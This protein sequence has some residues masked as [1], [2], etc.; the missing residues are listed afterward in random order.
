MRI[1]LLKLLLV[2]I[3]I[4]SLTA[5]NVYAIPYTFWKIQKKID[6]R[7]YVPAGTE[8]EGMLPELKG[9]N[10]LWGKLLTARLETDP[11]KAS[12]IYREIISSEGGISSIARLELARIRYASDDY[13][14]V[15]RLLSILPD[16]EESKI[17]LESLFFRGLSYKML[18]D[19]YRAR[20]DFKMID[21]GNYLYP[22]YM[23]LAEL[24][25]QTGN[26]TGAVRKYEAIGGIHS[27]PVAIFKLG[28]C[29]EILG[30]HG[31]A[32]KA[33]N[34]LRSN[35]PHSLEAP[36]AGG[37]INNLMSNR[38]NERKS[39]EAERI[40]EVESGDSTIIYTLQFGA[41][42]ERQNAEKLYSAISKSFPEARI[43]NI[44]TESG[45]EMFRVRS[46]RYRRRNRAERDSL[47]AIRE[48][49]YNSRILTIH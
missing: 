12:G 10:L 13:E 18:G 33:Y 2:G 43:E 27:N 29:Y 45:T 17:R 8:L 30:E 9:K 37:R 22:A 25:M 34:T 5:G 38:D 3:F 32:F 42:R 47:T 11:Q 46:G 26:Y 39:P 41:F 16:S 21:R 6:R 19:I 36:K 28:V 1:L 35:Y 40:K 15:I 24:D 4:F 20:K 14:D 48:H 44:L 49:G 7:E 23:E 31:K